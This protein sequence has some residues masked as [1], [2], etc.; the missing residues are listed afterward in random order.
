M[1]IWGRYVQAERG[2]FEPRITAY[3]PNAIGSWHRFE[4]LIDSGSDRTFLPSDY[5]ETLRIDLSTLPTTDNAVGVGSDRLA[6]YKLDTEMRFLMG[7]H[8]GHV[9][10]T[11]GI[12]RDEGLLDLPILGRDVLDEF[13]LILDRSRDIVA[14]L[15]PSQPNQIALWTTNHWLSDNR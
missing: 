12:F 8:I 10:L 4:F 6:Y 15:E 9:Q 7:R 13:A 3:L 5:A 14:L 11:I 1:Y 2:A